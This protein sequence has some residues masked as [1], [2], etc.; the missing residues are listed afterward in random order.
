MSFLFMEISVNSALIN[1][2]LQWNL[3]S[4]YTLLIKTQVLFFCMLIFNCHFA[5]TKCSDIGNFI[6]FSLVLALTENCSWNILEEQYASVVRFSRSC[7]LSCVIIKG[8]SGTWQEY[9]FT[10][11]I[12]W[13]TLVS[14]ISWKDKEVKKMGLVSCCPLVEPNLICEMAQEAA[15]SLRLP[16]VTDVRGRVSCIN[17]V[18]K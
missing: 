18:H 2:T 16:H 4:Y 14:R 13:H 12:Q 6:C 9:Y 3:V 7:L 8:P 5:C 1:I 10:Q 15:Q 17:H 11:G